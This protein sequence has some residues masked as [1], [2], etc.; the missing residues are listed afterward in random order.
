MESGLCSKGC[1]AR[2]VNLRHALLPVMSWRDVWM[3]LC[4]DQGTLYHTHK[5]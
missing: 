3:R 2:D 1:R 5:H 4:S